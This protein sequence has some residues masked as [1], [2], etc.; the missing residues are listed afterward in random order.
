[1]LAASVCRRTLPPSLVRSFAVESVSSSSSELPPPHQPPPPQSSKPRTRL[2]PHPRP[3]APQQYSQPLHLPPSFGKNQVLTVSDSTR[4]LL[5]EIVSEFHAPIRYAFAY[6]SGV[7]EQDGYAVKAPGTAAQ[8]SERPMVDF[9]FAVSHP[10]HWHSINMT[11]NPSHY[12]LHS[13]MLGSN[14]VSRVQEINPGIW[15]NA[16]VPMKGVVREYTFR[17][18]EVLTLVHVQTIKYGVTTVDNLCSDLLN[19]RSL[20][21]A[22][23]MHKPLRIIKDDA[24]V[25]LTQQ[26]N[27]VSA[28]RTALLSLPA[29]FSETELFERITG[30]SYAGD[31]RML[32]PAENRGKV[33]NIVRKQAPQFKELYHRL[34]TGLP[35]VHWSPHS[36]VIH[37]DASPESRSA[38]LR[39]LPSN[40]LTRVRGNYDHV[41][42]PLDSDE[43][44]YWVRMAGSENLPQ[45]LS[46]GSLCSRYFLLSTN[47][48]ALSRD[49]QH[50]QIPSHDP[51][52]QGDHQRRHRQESQVQLRQDVEVVAGRQGEG[53]SVRWFLAFHSPCVLVCCRIFRASSS[54]SYTTL[55]DIM[56]DAAHKYYISN[57]LH[58]HLWRWV[59][60]SL[61]CL[62]LRNVRESLSPREG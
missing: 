45:V 44:A 49:D 17:T 6:G 7:F 56:H 30:M 37:Q 27:L 48:H 16:Y 14:Y 55:M 53:F 57:N 61:T 1:M 54:A 47:E 13:R 23:R 22:G 18:R 4:A 19:W 59:A 34:V 25:R 24:R 50:R 33:G 26:V 10:D 32:L 42:P 20:Y 35:G 39:K 12:T 2:R 46:K 15:F 58:L 43:S 60:R 41:Q 51:V 38:L 36:S 31:P 8:A 9:M 5:E 11:Q 21:L 52:A 62:L 29:E 3:A 40:L 28:I